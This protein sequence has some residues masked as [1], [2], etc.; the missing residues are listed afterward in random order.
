MD[1]NQIDLLIKVLGFSATVASITIVGIQL[2]RTSAWKRKEYANDKVLKF[3]ENAYVKNA[4]IMLDRTGA[5]LVLPDIEQQRLDIKTI[6]YD[7]TLLQTALTKTD[8]FTDEEGFVRD[9]FDALFT[10]IE[11]LH[12]VCKSGLM[13]FEDLRPYFAYYSKIIHREIFHKS[14]ESIAAIN[15]YI[16][17]YFDRNRIP[18]FWREVKANYEIEN[19][20]QV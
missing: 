7:E 11:Q 4:L 16:S 3:F 6:E 13:K 19:P 9:C 12:D 5:T 8:L 17:H 1:N 10:G 14:P 2:K 15:V 18:E 20:P